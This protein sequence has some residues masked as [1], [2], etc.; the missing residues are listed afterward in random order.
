MD[1]ERFQRDPVQRRTTPK[2]TRAKLVR[3]PSFRD[4]VERLREKRTNELRIQK[5]GNAM[6]LP[7]ENPS[8]QKSK[9]KVITGW[10]LKGQFICRPSWSMEGRGS[11][12]E[13]VL[14]DRAWHDAVETMPSSYVA[15]TGDVLK[16]IEAY[17]Q[18]TS[19]PESLEEE[20]DE[21]GYWTRERSEQVEQRASDNS[22][23]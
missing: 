21:S 3:Q 13:Q 11:Q 6:C 12:Q 16:K 10:F 5:D 23:D 7:A 4:T 19:E 17:W 15:S 9:E 20:D 18:G 2:L 1:N 14:V 8:A 22:D